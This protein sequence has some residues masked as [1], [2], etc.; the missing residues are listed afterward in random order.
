MCVYRNIFIDPPISLCL[1]ITAICIKAKSQIFLLFIANITSLHF[2]LKHKCQIYKPVI[3][4]R[5]EYLISNSVMIIFSTEL[6]IILLFYTTIAGF[7]YANKNR[8]A[9]CF[10][11]SNSFPLIYPFCQF[12]SFTPFRLIFNCR[13]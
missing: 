13:F 8:E 12:L 1:I 7:I 9:L 6:A 2:F 11:F 5:I 3:E 4:I 10:Y